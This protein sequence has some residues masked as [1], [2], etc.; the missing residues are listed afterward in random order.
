MENNLL[1]LLEN[2][3][4]TKEKLLQRVQEDFELLPDLLKGVLSP[5][6]T[7][8]Y[9]C[10][11]V[12]VDL[13]ANCPNQIYPHFAV[14]SRLLES[15][16]RI[17][18]WN[19]ATVLANLCFVDVDKKFDALFDQY[20]SLLRSEYMVTVVNI[21]SNSSKIAL[22]KPNLIPRITQELLRVDEISTTPHLTEECKLVIAEKTIES[23]GKFFNFM[24]HSEQEKVI[25]FLEN[26]KFSSRKTLKG[27]AEALLKQTRKQ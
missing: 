19:A 10:S 23:F 1:K 2:K 20:F 4:L 7:V 25:S 21:V 12:L 3:M 22:A 18:T 24:N 6:A 15:N 9:G 27:K 17:L 5:T 14:F 13:S 11:S 8:R 16:Y 26:K